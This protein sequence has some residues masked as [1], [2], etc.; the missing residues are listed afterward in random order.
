MIRSSIIAFLLAISLALF[1]LA[2]WG[3]VEMSTPVDVPETTGKVLASPE[4]SGVLAEKISDEIW[5]EA[6]LEKQ[7]DEVIRVVPENLQFLEGMA[8]TSI[9]ST[10]TTAVSTILQTTFAEDIWSEGLLSTRSGKIIK[11]LGG[12]EMLLLER[13]VVYLDI[14]SVARRGLEEIGLPKVIWSNVPS[15]VGSIKL[16]DDEAISSFETSYS[17]ISIPPIAL[18]IFTFLFTLLLMLSERKTLWRAGAFLAGSLLA[19]YLFVFISVQ[20]FLRTPSEGIESPLLL[21][22]REIMFQAA[23]DDLLHAGRYCLYLAVPF[24]I[25]AFVF[26]PLFSH[27]RSKMSQNLGDGAE[28]TKKEERQ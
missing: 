11:P 21:S 9:K 12:N 16:L 2:S 8:K 5:R 28:Y 17:V 20:A 14:S 13:E 24:L 27:L 6:D 4:I 18:L 19:A 25:V 22:F 15:S 26:S 3:K 7:L 23:R 1:F 10:L